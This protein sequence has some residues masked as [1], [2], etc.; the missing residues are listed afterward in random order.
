[1]NPECGHGYSRDFLDEQLTQTFRLQTYKRHREQVLMDRERS[2]LPATQDD[3]TRYKEALARANELDKAIT[4]HKEKAKELYTPEVASALKVR[5]GIENAIHKRFKEEYVKHKHITNYRDRFDAATNATKAAKPAIVA[6]FNADKKLQGKAKAYALVKNYNKELR[7]I[8]A[9]MKPL[10]TERVIVR[11]IVNTVGLPQVGGQVERATF[12]MN[13][14]A[15]DCRGFLSSAWKCGLCS[16]W[17]CPDCRDVKGPVRDAEHTCDPTK[18]E[19]VKL[20]NKEAKACPKCGVQICKIEGCDQMWCTHCNTGFNWRT[21]TIAAGPIHNPHYFDWLR[22]QGREPTNNLPGPC[23]VIE[24]REIIRAIRTNTPTNIKLRSIWQNIRHVQHARAQPNF[25]NQLR[26]LR[27]KFM[28]GE[29]TETSWKTRLQQIEKR[30]RFTQA[31]E[32]V[33]ILFANA[34]LDLM[35][36][37]LTPEVNS[38]AVVKQVDGLITFCNDSLIN[39]SKRFNMK[40]N[41][42]VS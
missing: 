41:I 42:I 8:E 35:R 28:V 15:G 25:D 23:N 24:D 31:I 4:T 14:P 30:A 20:L 9:L 12:I 1:M 32:Q 40:A 2:K 6:A 13:C 22:N 34:A 37:L 10:H 36:Q 7:S 16:L 5:T 39:T 26:I 29:L 38:E 3:A 27:V 18:V 11:R 17:T 19:T 21:G 33:N